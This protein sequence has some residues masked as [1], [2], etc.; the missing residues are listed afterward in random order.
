MKQL[1]KLL[2]KATRAPWGHDCDEEDPEGLIETEDGCCI[3]RIHPHGNI[4]TVQKE[5]E[6][7]SHADARLIV[8]MRNNIEEL[9]NEN[10]KYEKLFKLC[11]SFVDDREIGHP[12]TVYQ[13]DYVI[14]DAYDFIRE[15]CD[16]VGYWEE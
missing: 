11:K 8:E 6:E 4:R 9:L 16:I 7:F 15:I 13:N 3:A 2:K 14:E 10:E 1:K 5:G 12:E